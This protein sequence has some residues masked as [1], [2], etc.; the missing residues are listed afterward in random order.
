MS[1]LTGIGILI[2]AT[3]ICLLY[4]GIQISIVSRRIERKHRD[5]ELLKTLKRIKERESQ[6]KMK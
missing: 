5:I 2:G 3:I 6:F 1:W 4:I